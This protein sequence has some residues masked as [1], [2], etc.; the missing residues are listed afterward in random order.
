MHAS[1][2]RE[3]H[4]RAVVAHHDAIRCDH[5]LPPDSL[6]LS[7]RYVRNPGSRYRVSQVLA[8]YTSIFNA[9]RKDIGNDRIAA[10]SNLKPTLV[11]SELENMIMIS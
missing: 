3:T 9:F 1:R 6:S 8:L 2:E 4:P 5:L 11:D 10:P 7:V